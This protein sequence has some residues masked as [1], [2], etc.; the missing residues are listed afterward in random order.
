MKRKVARSPDPFSMPPVGEDNSFDSCSDR[1]SD[2]DA[3]SVGSSVVIGLRDTQV[4]STWHKVVLTA[5]GAVA[6]HSN[7]YI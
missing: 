1:S 6:I 2:E 7:K 3:V 5:S 4:L